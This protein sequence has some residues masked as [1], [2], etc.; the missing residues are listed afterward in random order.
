MRPAARPEQL[1]A[2]YRS[3][4]QVLHSLSAAVTQSDQYSHT[5]WEDLVFGMR[6]PLNLIRH[7]WAILQSL[8]FYRTPSVRATRKWL[9]VYE[10]GLLKTLSTLSFPSIATNKL[11]Y[12][13]TAATPPESTESIFVPAPHSIPVRILHDAKLPKE[14]EAV[15][16]QD[17]VVH[18]H[19]GG[20][21]GLSSH[22]M[23][24]YTRH[25]A[26]GLKMPFFSID[27]RQPPEHPFPAPPEDCLAVYKF[28]LT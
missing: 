26:K 10:Q 27:Y 4:E 17:I 11:I 24:N 20:F 22:T 7:D 14:G 13:P 1:K 3:V 19:G 23:Q 12:V 8:Q 21:L 16:E 6:L 18:M 9:N 25:W 2:G 28:L 5:P 15:V